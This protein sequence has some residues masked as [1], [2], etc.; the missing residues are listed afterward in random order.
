[1][2]G[3]KF[4]DNY[5][6]IK[7]MRLA[8]DEAEKAGG[9]NEVPVGAV[10]IKNG[11]LV[12]AAFNTVEADK[13]SVMHAEIK[14]ILKAQERLDNWRLTDCTL[15]VTLEPCLMCCGAI[16]LS[17]ITRLVYGAKDPKA[18]AAG[19]LYDTLRD[20]RL[21]HRVETAGGVMETESSQLLKEFFM[22]KRRQKN[23]A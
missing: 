6:D 9:C 17:R 10:I 16:L 19:S 11:E 2:P 18:G 22:G 15:Y 14:A 3:L 13:S 20:E 12:A 21:N 23:E 4:M 1:M 5:S 7:F 8:L